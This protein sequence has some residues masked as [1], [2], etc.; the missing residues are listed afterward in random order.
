VGFAAVEA[1]KRAR[2]DSN[3]TRPCAT[4]APTHPFRDLWDFCA[5]VDGRSVNKKAIEALIKCGAFGSTGD[6]RKGMLMVLEQAQGAGQKA[7]QD[8]EIGQGSI[9]DGL[10]GFGAAGDVAGEPAIS[11]APIPT[12]EFDRPELLAAEKESLGLFI[13]EHPLK[14]VRSALMARVDCSLAELA[15]RRDG[16]P[17]APAM[18]W[19]RRT[20][21][22][23]SGARW[24]TRIGTRP[25]WWPNS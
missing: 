15:S 25:A 21:W 5:R 12:L 9:F 3:P 11:H 19:S 6:T 13:S 2:G 8:A 16:K 22:C 17:P 7:Q 24:I 1:I 10:D 20:P 23:S 4:G 14:Q 18:T